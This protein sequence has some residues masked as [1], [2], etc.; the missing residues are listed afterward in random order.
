MQIRRSS[1]RRLVLN[2]VGTVFSAWP[3]VKFKV[4]R[5]IARLQCAQL[6]SGE[7]RGLDSRTARG[8]A[9]LLTPIRTL[10]PRSYGFTAIIPLHDVTA[11]SAKT[12]YAGNEHWNVARERT[13][14][15]LQLEAPAAVLAR[16]KPRQASDCLEF[17]FSSY[18]RRERYVFRD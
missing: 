9:S 2:Y 13:V 18:I 17:A 4:L 12:P 8:A 3:T 1:R 16:F 7:S 14:I 10:R 5:R 11:A 6:E 15:A